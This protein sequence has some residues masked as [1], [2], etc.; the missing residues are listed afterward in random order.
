MVHNMNQMNK[1]DRVLAVVEGTRPDR[2]PISFWHHFGSDQRSGNAAVTA[3]LKHLD[4]HDLDFLKVMYDLGYPG[5]RPIRS[6]KQLSELIV[7][8]GDHGPF[9]QHLETIRALAA[10][11]RGRLLITTTI[12]N[13]W[14]MLRRLV[15]EQEHVPG[16][17]GRPLGD[18]PPTIRL[19]EFLAEDRNAVADAL[20]IIAQ[21][22]ANF[23]RS[24]IDAGAD[25]IFLSV[26]DD[27]V[28]TPANG[29]G[30]YDEVVRAA[31]GRILQSAS[32]GRFNVLHV[33]GRALNFSA[34]AEYPVHVINWADRLA[35]PAIADVVGSLKPAPCGG[36]DHFTTLSGDSEQAGIAEVRDAIAQAGD[37][38]IIVA[39][40]CTYDPNRVP[41]ANLQAVRRTVDEL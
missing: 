35:G 31:D 28:D 24:C 36:I 5:P 8:E 6:V 2:P 20:T 17:G 40:G 41:L 9:G 7:L 39:P 21:S 14:A 22:L 10:E 26:R 15:M 13:A 19:E 29:P 25:G 11:L 23:A 34:F 30:T 1:I 27:W 33:C 12:F 4:T 38:P 18:D 37:R 3:H 16:P 32:Q